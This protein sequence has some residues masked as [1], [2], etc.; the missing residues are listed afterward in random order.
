MRSGGDVDVFYQLLSEQS[1][2]HSII[3]LEQLRDNL[4]RIFVAVVLGFHLALAIK[5]KSLKIERGFESAIAQAH[6]FHGLACPLLVAKEV[7][8]PCK[9]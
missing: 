4:P 3:T 8:M 9:H 6:S 5:D 2:E 7:C 1:L